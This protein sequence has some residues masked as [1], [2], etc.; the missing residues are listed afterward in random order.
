MLEQMLV[1]SYNH[2]K[3]MD[4]IT[5]GPNTIGIH[6]PGEKM[7]IASFDRTYGYFKTILAKL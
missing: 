2:I 3:D 1:R 5:L 4:V 7:E 6:K